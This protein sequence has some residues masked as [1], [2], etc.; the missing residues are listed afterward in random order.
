MQIMSTL[1]QT[2]FPCPALAEFVRRDSA[3][4]VVAQLMTEDRSDALEPERAPW[5]LSWFAFVLLV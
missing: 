5:N 4:D 1:A 3:G 2:M